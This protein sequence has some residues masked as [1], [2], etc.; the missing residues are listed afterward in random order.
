M[1]WANGRRSWIISRKYFA[2][3][4]QWT[5]K[6]NGATCTDERK[7]NKSNCP[8][9]SGREGKYHYVF[10]DKMIFSSAKLRVIGLL[11]RTKIVSI[12]EF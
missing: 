2:S 3:A 12:S 1:E 5:S 10:T 7:Q 8:E 6:T 11:S 4:A 9:K